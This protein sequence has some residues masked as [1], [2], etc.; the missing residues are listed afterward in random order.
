MRRTDISL[1]EMIRF[2]GRAVAVLVVSILLL[3]QLLSQRSSTSSARP[4]HPSIPGGLRSMKGCV[5]NDG[6]KGI[7][8]I[9]QRGTKIPLSGAED[10][11]THIGQQVRASGAFVEKDE[12][13][14]PATKP[15]NKLRPEHEFRVIKIDVLSQTCP[16]GKKK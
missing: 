16:S 4:R 13:S 6:E 5:V 7:A 2:L 1:K 3:T 12:S 9:S 8:L 11:S 10:L 14:D 15:E